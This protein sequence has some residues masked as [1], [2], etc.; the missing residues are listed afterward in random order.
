MAKKNI[1]ELE[2]GEIEWI[3]EPESENS[4]NAMNIGIVTIYPNSSQNKHI[5]YGDEQVLYVLSGVGKQLIGDKISHIQ[6]G[7]LHHIEVGS[8]HETINL[9]DEPIKELLISIPVHRDQNLPIPRKTQS[10]IVEGSLS[11]NR[12]T[13]NEEIGY[14]YNGII[15]LLK[16]PVAIFDEEGNTV[17]TGRYYPELCREK[18]GIEENVKKCPIYQMRDEYTPPYYSDPSAYVCPYGLTI[19]IMPIVFDNRV[20]G[21]I[22]GGHIR[23]SQ[24]DMHINQYTQIKKNILGEAAYAAMHIVPKGTVNAI[25]QQIKKLSKNIANYYL[26][27]NTAVA[28]NKQEEIIQDIV[29]NESILE[30]SLKTAKDKALNIQIGNHFLFNTLN[31]IAGLAVKEK[32]DKTYEAIIDLSKLMRYTLKNNSYF[33]YLQEEVEY[34]KNYINL[35]QLRYGNRLKVYFNVS[36]DT[37]RKKIPFNCLQPIVENCF[38]HGFKNMKEGMEIRITAEMQ[39]DKLTL[40]IM[41]NGRG[42]DSDLQNY[43]YDKLQEDKKQG[44]SGLMMVYEKLDLLFEGQFTFLIESELGLG[45]RVTIS[46]P[47]KV[48]SMD[49]Q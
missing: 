2:W 25:L 32:A 17:I 28:L 42:M 31:A 8:I 30:E 49:S 24:I 43:V 40:Q 35:Q 29:R 39:E 26:F 47:D 5:H 37:S 45:T 23:T 7:S 38:I 48:S 10:M 16:I 6:A 27:K 36:G 15:E 14:I 22:K 3:Y 12:V 4:Q 44:F 19:F 1:Q 18:C 34:L 11:E 13:V 9:G 20:I 33:V 46:L 21:L 41:D